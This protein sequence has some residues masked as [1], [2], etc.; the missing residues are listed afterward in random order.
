[1]RIRMIVLTCLQATASAQVQ[2]ADNDREFQ[3]SA[4]AMME[5]L[6]KA[7]EA[8]ATNAAYLYDR[9]HIPQR[10]GTQGHCIAKG[11]WA[12][13]DIEDPEHVD[14]RRAAVG[15]PPMTEYIASMKAI[16]GICP[17]ADPTLPGESL[18]SR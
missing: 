5:P 14:Q 9:T 15:L 2:H 18:N 1:M 17:A 10:Y 12:P 8:S 7:G 3:K 11:V 16:K 6:L 4:L 13:Q